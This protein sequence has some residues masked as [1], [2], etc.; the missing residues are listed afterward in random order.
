M[1]DTPQEIKEKRFGRVVPILLVFVGLLALGLIY[2]WAR[3]VKPVERVEWQGLVALSPPLVFQFLGVDPKA[4]NIGNWKDWEK[5]LSNHPRIRKVRITRDPDGFLM[6]NIQEKVAE[7]VIH[8]GSSLY[9]VDENLEILSRDRVLA[10][11]L[12]V[13]SG[14]FT[15][16]ENKL[17]GRQIF[18]ITK[19][20]RQA[21]SLYPTLKS[22]ISELVSESDGNYTLYLKSPNSIKVYLGDKLELDIFRKLYASLAYMESEAVKAV[23]IDLRGEDAVYH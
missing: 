20:M 9:E 16:G 12:I 15:V 18:D 21:L 3:P 13:I 19:E 8:V 4:P 7:F 5:Q 17:E 1:V 11:H 22:R 10:D 6:I 23:S 2:R 14:Q